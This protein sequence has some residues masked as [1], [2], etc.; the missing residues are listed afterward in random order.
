MREKREY[1]ESHP[2]IVEKILKEGTKKAREEAKKNITRI[3]KAMKL[4]YFEG[5]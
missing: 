4:N 1:Y 5:E 3:K 2:E